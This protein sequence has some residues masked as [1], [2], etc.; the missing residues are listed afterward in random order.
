MADDYDS[1]WKDAIE[2]Y[3]ADF[4]LFYFP[5]AHA[6]VDWSAPPVFL[7]QEL[8]AAV[9]DA[10]LG[11]R[12]VDKLVRVT[13]LGGQTGWVYV[14]IEVQGTM[15]AEFAERMF[16]YH[17][18]LYERYNQPIASL[19]LLADDKEHWRPETFGYDMFGCQLALRFPVAKLLDWAGSEA[20]LADSQNPFAIVT[21]AHLS[22]RAT[23]TDPQARY[24]AKWVLVKELYRRGWDRKQVIDLMRILD[25]MMRLPK[26]LAQTLRQDMQTLEEEMGKPYVTSFERLATEEG[27]AK[28][29]QQ[30]LQQGMQ[31]GM[32]QGIQQGIHQGQARALARLLVRRFGEEVPAW[33]I[34]KL[35]EATETELDAWTD[36][37]LSAASIEAVFG[38]ES[39]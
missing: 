23:R 28:G 7:D 1:P 36:A 2:R 25:W 38:A 9:H 31:Q 8:R 11:T 21:Q 27:M 13:R 15:Q 3:F 18:R 14:H 26:E 29:M 35:N 17:Y 37:V 12:I 19:A 6:Q 4:L 10:E 32:Q 5:E 39:H 34:A 20:R 33:A 22:T 16:V 30:G 24:A